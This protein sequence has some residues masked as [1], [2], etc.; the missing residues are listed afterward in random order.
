[1]KRIL[2]PALVLGILM[3]FAGDAAALV[4]ENPPTYSIVI[5]NNSTKVLYPVISKGI[6][7][8]VTG[9]GDEWL[10][11]EFATYFPDNKYP[12]FPTAY[13]YRA[14]IDITRG[15]KTIGLEGGDNVTIT[16]PFFTQLK[17][18]KDDDIGR[19]S[20]QFIDWFNA[21]RLYLFE[22]VNAFNAADITDGVNPASV[23]RPPATPEN[24]FC[25]HTPTVITPL[26]GAAVPTC[27]ASTSSSCTVTI[28]SY[29]IEPPTNIPFQLQEYTFLSAEKDKKTGMAYFA[30]GLH[31][32]MPGNWMNYNVSS[33][34]SVYLPV[35]MGTL[36][37][38]AVP[39]VGS[40][41][42]IHAF[43]KE[44]GD[45]ANDGSNWPTF[46]PVYFSAWT[47]T[48]LP[49]QTAGAL[50]SFIPYNKTVAYALPKLP[51]AAVMLTESYAGSANP[52]I[53]NPPVPPILTSNPPPAVFAKYYPTATS[54]TATCLSTGVAPFSTPD[55]G[56]TGQGVV[57]LWNN[58][59]TNMAGG[60]ECVDIRNV[61]DFFLKNY[62]NKCGTG[63]T[64][65]LVS[66]MRDIYGFVPI[67]YPLY[68]DSAKC[69]GGDLK[70]TLGA[71]LS[72]PKLVETYCSLQYNYL[73]GATGEEIFNPYTQLIHKTLASTAYAFSIDDGVSFKHAEGTGVVF[74][75]GGPNGLP[76]ETPAPLPTK[77]TI[78]EQCAGHL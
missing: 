29:L 64:P 9:P 16:V 65:D 72:Y 5:Y 7:S 49:P 6:T 13:V 43:H 17:E 73:T 23:C 46:R 42:T 57:N 22:G 68:P 58:C 15:G 56:T 8:A 11:A 51:G 24:H 77:D 37:N 28:K 35:A 10:H 34:D 60:A 63:N 18:V 19:V 36:G 69:T 32:E 30:D 66:A 41:Q 47:N 75:V 71:I 2:A 59:I 62:I 26:Q 45:F 44:L 31:G 3:V 1:M 52:P 70:D 39:Y 78:L 4:P 20:D 54:S 38:S 76:N 25:Y 14:V 21:N 53:T 27:K 50:C 67:T 55:L 40:T 48:A 12:R 33:L 61:Y 74:A